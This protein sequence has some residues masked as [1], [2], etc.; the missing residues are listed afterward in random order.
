[1]TCQ[2][3]RAAIATLDSALHRRLIGIDDL[4]TVFAALPARFHALRAL[5]DA[6]AESGPETL[7]RLMARVLGCDVRL[8]V[9]FDDIGRVDLLLDGWLVVECDSR[10]F[11]QDWKTQVKDRE[12]DVALAALGYCTLRVTAAMIMYRPDD[13]FAALRGLISS[14]RAV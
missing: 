7:V 9:E 1:M 3:P 6:R 14:R 12:R 13:V 10:E 11:H 8:Q 4:N 5:V 2:T